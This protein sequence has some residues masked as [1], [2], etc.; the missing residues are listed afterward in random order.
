[1]SLLLFCWLFCASAFHLN[2]NI[3][4]SK[5]AKKE[6]P[7]LT[8]K[9][10]KLSCTMVLG[11]GKEMAAEEELECAYAVARVMFVFC[12]RQE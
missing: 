6:T 5:Q 7:S 8:R 10:K 12:K 3:N 2:E 9:A 4:M 11:Q 1:M